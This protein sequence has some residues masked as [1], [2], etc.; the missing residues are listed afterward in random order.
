[1]FEQPA[2][3]SR[4][5]TPTMP[6][7]AAANQPAPLRIIKLGGSLLGLPAWPRHLLAWLGEQPPMRD[8]LIVG[9]GALADAIRQ[10]AASLDEETAHWQCID[11]L[12]A[13]AD[14]AAELLSRDYDRVATAATLA[15]LR[16]A[17]S[18]GRLTV[19]NPK[20]FLQTEEASLRGTPL[21]HTWAA[22]SDS[23]AARMAF[24]ADADELVLLK[25]CDPP[26]DAGDLHGLADAGYVDRHFP[27]AAAGLAVRL[28]D[29]RSYAANASP[30]SAD[31]PQGR[32]AMTNR[33]DG[34]Q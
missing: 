5:P 3:G 9:G 21:P 18:Y 26:G 1:M 27:A 34:P 24:G 7:D 2:R 25:S 33:I 19:F 28:V 10:T 17:G 11:A 12:A 15:S 4:M 13:N 32:S 14:R 31:E 20:P 29:L 30:A 8:V 6:S 23:I 22:T 16:L